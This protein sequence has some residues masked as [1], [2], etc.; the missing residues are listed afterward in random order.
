MRK[1]FFTPILLMIAIS[2]N[3]I[4]DLQF[5]VKE[6]TNLDIENAGLKLPAG[7]SASALADSVGKARHIVVTKKGALYIKLSKLVNG[8]GILYAKDTDADG[9]IDDIKSFGNYI[10]TG[11]TI[12][13]GYLY[14]SS[15]DEVFRYALDENEEVIKPDAPEKIITGLINGR[16][17][18][19][20]S[21]V[22]DDKGNIYVNVG[23][24]SN[25]C[26][27]IDRGTGSKGKDPCPIL[28]FCRR[29]MAIQS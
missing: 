7:F 26:Q 21:L 23:S 28:G 1:Y 13:D 24:P 25:S 14:A 17:H 18:N 12:K 29:D 6:K 2:M 10:G 22:L 11:I 19:T 16:Q 4:S 5:E 3:P 8:K 27:E 9:K 15:N 20:K